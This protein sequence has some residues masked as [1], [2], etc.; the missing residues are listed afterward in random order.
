MLGRVK[1]AEVTDEVKWTRR[2]P[3]YSACRGHRERG[4]RKEVDVTSQYEGDG[5]RSGGRERKHDLQSSVLGFFDAGR[6]ESKTSRLCDFEGGPLCYFK[7]RDF[8]A[9]AVP[10]Y[11]LLTYLLNLTFSNSTQE[12]QAG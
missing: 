4:G 8:G 12:R 2:R 5:G 6:L 9:D 10:E 7:T 3:P 11:V 1:M